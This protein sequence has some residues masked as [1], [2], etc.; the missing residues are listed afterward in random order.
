MKLS[1][2][3]P[4]YNE[5]A[6][7]REILKKIDQINMEKEIIIVDDASTDDTAK[8]LDDIKNSELAEL[9]EI[10]VFHHTTNKGKGSA[11]RTAIPHISGDIVIIQ[12]A[13]LEYDPQDYYKLV[14]PITEDGFKVVYGSRILNKRNK[15]S[16][17]S[18]YLGGRLITIITNLL[19]G[20]KLTDEP[21][22][23]KVFQA[24][25]LKSIPL[26]C[27]TFEFC[28]EVTAKIALRKIPIHEVPINYY[29]RKIEE[30]KKITWKDGIMAIKTLLK[31]RFGNE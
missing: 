8:I 22:C 11:I 31:Y 16:Y 29:P 18:F 23:Y 19:Y 3:I 6:T 13:D 5:S 15:S 1:I 12:D 21:T 24:K 25:L 20:L 17:S 7:L 26:E 2:I 14:K 27:K 28:P 4:S 10:K 9:A 30:G